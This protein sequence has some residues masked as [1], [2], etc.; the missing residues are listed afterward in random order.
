MVIQEQPRAYHPCGPQMRLLRQHELQRRDDMR[1][2]AEKHYALGQ[3]FG[4]E[5]KFVVLE[6][7]Q[8]AMDQLRAPRRGM[9]GQIV[10]LDQQCDETASRRIARNARAVDTA[11]DNGEIV[12]GLVGTWHRLRS[13]GSASYRSGRGGP[14]ALTLHLLR[15]LSLSRRYENPARNRLTRS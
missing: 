11:A 12:H 4:H 9:R 2:G 3:G 13:L 15:H 14:F 8:A 1:R 6:I 7:A 10:F 5:P